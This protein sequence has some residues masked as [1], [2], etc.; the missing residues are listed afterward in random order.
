MANLN[1]T[2]ADIEGM[3]SNLRNGQSQLNEIL[4]KLKGQVDQLVASGFVTDKASGAFQSS[5]SEFT[6]GATKA[7]NGLEGM[8]AFLS[9]TQQAMRELDTQL[10]GALK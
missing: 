7:V 6:N 1:V 4:N 9:K 5:Y 10:A 8:H 2:Y 3:V